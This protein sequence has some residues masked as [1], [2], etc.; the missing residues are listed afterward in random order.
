MYISR[1]TGIPQDP[2]TY[3]TLR[4]TRLS[5]QT[6]LAAELNYMERD[7]TH[8][9]IRLSGRVRGTSG[10]VAGFFTYRNDTVESDIEILTRDP[11]SQVRYSNQPTEDPNTEWKCL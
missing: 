3:L 1:N 9:S 11:A 8:A 10:A 7:V 2:L 5:K 4:T 6:Q